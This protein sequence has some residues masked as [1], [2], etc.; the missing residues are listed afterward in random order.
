MVVG[1]S[2]GVCAKPLQ[3]SNTPHAPRVRVSLPCLLTEVPAK[4]TRTRQAF[5]STQPSAQSD[6]PGTV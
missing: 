5:V 6:L 4:V 1:E 2:P 3:A